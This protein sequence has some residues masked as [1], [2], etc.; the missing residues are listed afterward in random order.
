ME[1]L[2]DYLSRNLDR[3]VDVTPHMQQSLNRLFE[4]WSAKDI[5]VNDFREI[6]GLPEDAG[7]FT[8]IPFMTK[9][10]NNPAYVTVNENETPYTFFI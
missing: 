2:A 1:S 5:T 8:I 7:V 10:A 9:N 3:M 6:Y 4:I